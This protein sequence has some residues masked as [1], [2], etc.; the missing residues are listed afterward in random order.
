MSKHKKQHFIPACYT[1]AWRDPQAPA[2]HTP[3]VWLYNKDG[4]NPRKKAPENIFHETDLYTI[5]EGG[6]RN[7]RLEKGLCQ[8]ENEFT[9][10]RNSK[11]NFHRELSEMDQIVLCA[12]TAAAHTRTPTFRDHQKEQWKRPLEMME[13]LM[14]KVAVMT[15]E[16]KKHFAKSQPPSLGEKNSG[17][18]YEAVKAMHDNPL[19]TTLFTFIQT[20]TPL[21]CQLD[22]AFLVTDDPVGFITSD[23]PC[24]WFDPEAYKR[25]PMYRGPALMY[26]TIE[27]T[28]P[29]SPSCMMLLNRQGF[30]GYQKVGKHTVT[31][32]NRRTRGYASDYFVVNQAHVEP[33]WLEVGEGPDDSWEKQQAAK[34]GKSH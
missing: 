22:M 21:L 25:P 28:L 24:V 14:A 4:S 16:Q 15:P 26:E 19:Q 3:Y 30:A 34:E 13:E 2:T 6:E 10:V 1:K 29:I 18:D 20:E 23:H 11:L 12:F 7:L 5:N 17:L 27:I 32:M 9:K 31:E 33:R 8:L